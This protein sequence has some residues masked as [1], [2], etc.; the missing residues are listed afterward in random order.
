[1]LHFEQTM[2]LSMKW[3]GKRMRAQGVHSLGCYD[4]CCCSQVLIVVVWSV[5]RGTSAEFEPQR[6]ALSQD[7]RG[8]AIRVRLEV[9]LLDCEMVVSGRWFV[10]CSLLF[11]FLLKYLSFV[12][13]VGLLFFC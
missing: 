11:V 12:C 4:C 13:T 5:H 1:M 9:T 8:R 10:C 3:R 7:R 6:S 2:E